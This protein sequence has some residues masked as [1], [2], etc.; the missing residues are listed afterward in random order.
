MNDGRLHILVVKTGGLGDVVRTSYFARALREKWG[1]GLRLSWLTAAAAAPLLRFNPYIDDPWTSFAEARPYCYDR[2]YSLD[3]E[4]DVLEGVTSL[5]F[6]TITGA[7]LREG[8]PSYTD[9]AAGWFDMGLL[10]RFGKA[11]ADEL[12]KLNTRGHAEIFSEIFGVDGVEPHFFGNPRLERWAAHLLAEHSRVIGINPFAGGRWPSKELR[13]SELNTLIDAIV[14]GES[15]FGPKCTVVL[16]GAGEDHHRNKALAAARPGARILVP[17]TDDSVLRLAALI[18][19]LHTMITSDSLAMH[20]AIAQHVPTV[21]FFAPTSAAEIDDFGLVR[22]VVSTAPD[23]CSYRKDAD[24]TSLTA[25]RL[26]EQLRLLSAVGQVTAGGSDC[27]ARSVSV[28][29][30]AQRVFSRGH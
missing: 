17:N 20:L 24:N 25:C 5:D 13:L 21:A 27:G 6:R 23:Y 14:G 11:R 18:G 15:V 28:N 30:G 16:F 1:D 3:D 22:K 12:K 2:V 19:R 10:S 7:F 8:T 26:L 9:D 4:R 29:S